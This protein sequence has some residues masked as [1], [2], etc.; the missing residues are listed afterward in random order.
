[1]ILSAESNNLHSPQAG[2]QPDLHGVLQHEI[3]HGIRGWVLDKNNLAISLTVTICFDDKYQFHVPAD[4]MRQDLCDGIV[5][6][7]G[8]D[9]KLI[10]LPVDMFES[11]IH[12]IRASV[13]Q[14]EY[15]L[16]QSPMLFDAK[17]IARDLADL[18]EKDMTR[19]VEKKH[20]N[21]NA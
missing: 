3:T 6:N 5:G 2:H 16:T 18:C 12:Q 13:V 9:L 14:H 11:P 17:R 19:L 20:V 21:W 7:Y 8:F 15:E 4:Q 1:M 10:D